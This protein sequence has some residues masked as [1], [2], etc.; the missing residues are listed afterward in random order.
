MML[1]GLRELEMMLGNSFDHAKGTRV[2]RKAVVRVWKSDLKRSSIFKNFLCC[3]KN[4]SRPP[5]TYKKNC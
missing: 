2:G 3:G 5:Q 4:K 1:D